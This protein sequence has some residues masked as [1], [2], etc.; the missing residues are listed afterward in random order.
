[1]MNYEKYWG[2]EFNPF[3][4]SFEDK[5]IFKSV[6]F[7]QILA[8]LEHLKNTKGIGLFTGNPGLGKT[9]ALKQFTNTLNKNLYKIVYIS[10]STVT[11]LEFYK[12]LAHGLGLI[13]SAKKVDLYK[14]IQERIISLVKSKK[15][16]PVIII[17]EA[18]YLKTEVLN[19]VK[20]LLNF[21]MD[22]VN[23]VIFILNGQPI[24]NDIL[25]RGI[26]EALKQRIV[27]NYNSEGLS[28]KEIKEYIKSSLELAGIHEPIFNDNTYEAIFSCSN[29]SIRK[30]N[31][32]VDKCLLIAYNENTREIDTNIVM[33]AQNELELYV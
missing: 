20:L 3:K 16:T 31:S 19:D 21:N 6:D 25:S 11:V 29:K 9:F 7:N 13:P 28:T 22:S 1:M 26:H 32:L 24:L 12:S 18:Q 10:L 5:N 30:V 15:I 17:D 4:K 2:M 8:R 14:S 27:I 33:T 23:H